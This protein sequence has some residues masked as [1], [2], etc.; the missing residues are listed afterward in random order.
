MDKIVK[1]PVYK[2][3]GIKNTNQI[4]IIP[5]GYLL[6]EKKMSDTLIEKVDLSKNVSAEIYQCNVTGS[7]LLST[8]KMPVMYI[9]IISE[10][11][12]KTEQLFKIFLY[13]TITTDLKASNQLI[14]CSL[15]GKFNLELQ[16]PENKVQVLDDSI[17]H[18]VGNKE[19]IV[20]MKELLNSDSIKELIK[21]YIELENK[22][23]EEVYAKEFEYFG[24]PKVTISL[25]EYLKKTK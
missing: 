19:F 11:T 25:K 17:D 10:K 23:L 1:I 13:F 24:K 4:K 8:K 20:K 12:L 6:D 5:L 2:I 16:L 9:K 14:N 3:K 21:M 7:Y 15:D 22:K 18:Y